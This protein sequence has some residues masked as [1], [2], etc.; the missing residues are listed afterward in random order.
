VPSLREATYIIVALV[1]AG[2]T[3]LAQR[4]A[5]AIALDDFVGTG[6][7]EADAPGLAIWALD[8]VAKQD[9]EGAFGQEI[10][11]HVER[12]L[13]IILE[14]LQARSPIYQPFVGPVAAHLRSKPYAELSAVAQRAQ[15]G[16]IRGRHS[17]DQPLFFVNAVSYL[18]LRHAAALAERLGYVERARWIRERAAALRRAF[19]AALSKHPDRGSAL[20]A[21]AGLWPSLIADADAGGYAALL[22]QRWARLR[23]PHGAFQSR[24][25]RTYLDV[26]EAHQWLRLDRSDRVWATIEWLFAHQSSPGLF[27]WWEQ[28][29]DAGGSSGRWPEVRGW[30]APTDATPHYWTAAEMALLQLEM[31]ALERPMGTGEG[32]ADMEIV[33]GA[34][35]PRA[36]ISRPISVRGVRLGCGRVDWRWDGRSAVVN[37]QGDAHGEIRL[38]SAFPADATIQLGEPQAA[39]DLP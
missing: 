4:L 39:Q 17:L 13:Q 7:S 3:D 37:W 19:R 32:C 35:V 34:G 29:E 18:G 30:L 2:E 24:P 9:P 27:T 5:A 20:T 12:K 33:L 6:G 25:E 38:G 8:E 22:E 36:W 21:A 14:M 23:T 10:W 11:P 16:L 15:G 31:L 1:R 28:E 26:A